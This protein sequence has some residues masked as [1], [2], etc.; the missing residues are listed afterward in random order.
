[1]AGL[2]AAASRAGQGLRVMGS[3]LSP[4]GAG[5]SSGGVMSMALMDRVI[6]VDADKKQ[7]TVQA[8]ARVQAVA[9]ALKPHGLTLQ[10]YASIRDQQVGGFTQVGAHGTGAAI[11]PVDDQ[12]VG[13]KLATPGLGTL[14]LS[15][16]SE[17]ELF[18][19]AKVGLGGL[20]VVTEVTLQCVDAHQLVEETLTAS[21]A[22]VKK[23]HAAW[24][25]EYRHLRYM[26]LP[27]TDSVVVVRSN[28]AG[29]PLANAAL[30]RA[31]P[32]A[33]QPVSEQEQARRLQ[34]LRALVEARAG[35]G[36]ASHATSLAALRDAALELAPLDRD[37]VAA[38]N[39]AEAACWAASAGVRV[40]WS[41]EVLGFDCGGQQWVLETAFP[42]GKLAALKGVT[43][44]IEYMEA[45]LKEIRAHKVPAP[46]PIEQRWTAGSRSA[47]SPARGP[48]D[49]VHAWVGVIMYLPHDPA[50]R[51]AV[52][53]AFRSYAR[54]VNE[55]LVPRYNAVWHWAK[56]ELPPGHD[57]PGSEGAKEL[58][59]IRARLAARYPV[60]LYNTYREVVDPNNVLANEWLSALLPR[61]PAPKQKQAAGGK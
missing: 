23:H 38:V 30:A 28:P 16:D 10:N 57:Q 50:A 24:L 56:L 36:S 31:G 58:A 18:A 60:A 14:S 45:L 33:L 34:P 13:L 29:H 54:L 12:V 20:G 47:L 55:R 9:D 6:K 2:L 5:L 59:R 41:D 17:P 42:V 52:T 15:A 48:A 22:E 51:S 53:D 35:P 8:G 39:A 43:R 11:P 7:V 61:A 46:A 1:V 25:R 3:G 44:D 49:E 40:G 26:W 32:A 21:L 37:W 19:L 27:Y 4:N